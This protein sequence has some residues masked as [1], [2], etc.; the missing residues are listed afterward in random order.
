MNPTCVVLRDGDC[1]RLR[2]HVRDTMSSVDLATD[3][4]I[5]K[6][7]ELGRRSP[8]RKQA[9]LFDRLAFAEAFFE[10]F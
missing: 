3:R 6:S 10:Q 5:A 1:A 9:P 4:R 7:Q 2:S 8:R